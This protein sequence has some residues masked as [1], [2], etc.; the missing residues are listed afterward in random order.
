MF[1][2]QFNMFDP[3]HT[4]KVWKRLD[5]YENECTTDYHHGSAC[6]KVKK[7]VSP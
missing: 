6:S 5:I 2:K 1:S 3:L 4:H 7:Y